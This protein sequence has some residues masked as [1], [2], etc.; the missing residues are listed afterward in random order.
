MNKYKIIY[1]FKD[2]TIEEDNNLGNYFETQDEADAA[3]MEA[4]YHKDNNIRDFEIVDSETLIPANT[5]SNEIRYCFK[6]GSN[7]STGISFCPYCGTPLKEQ[8]NSSQSQTDDNRYEP[9]Y[10]DASAGSGYEIT[11]TLFM[12]LCLAGGIACFAGIFLP[13]VS[14]SFLGTSLSASL[15]ELMKGEGDFPIFVAV[16]VIGI[17]LAMF[18]L[19]LGCAID[20]VLFIIIHSI[21]TQDYWKELSGSYV[22]KGAGYYAMIG[23]AICLIIF[24]I[25]GSV[26]K[27]KYKH[28]QK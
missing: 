8:G 10:N 24:G 19:F 26:E 22:S 12:V 7:L 27:M 3:G 14:A 6:C 25:T 20:G 13:Y 18:K 5:T 28:F 21:D 9:T 16:A 15:Q 1:H 4:L 11:K 23:G 2:G 17:V